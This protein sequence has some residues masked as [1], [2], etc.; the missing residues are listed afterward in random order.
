MKAINWNEADQGVTFEYEDIPA[1]LLPRSSK[2]HQHLVES[3]AEATEELME[4]YLGGEEFSEVE[5]KLLC[6]IW[7]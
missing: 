6:V 7:H 5:L 1:E 4:K 3:A 2:W